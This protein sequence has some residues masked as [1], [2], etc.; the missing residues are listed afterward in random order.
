MARITNN[1]FEA[2]QKVTS[3]EEVAE[4]SVDK[5]HYCAT[6]VEHALLGYG[7]CISEQHA[8]PDENGDIAWYTVKFPTGTHK[9]NTEQ[10][11]IVEGKSH[12]HSKKMAEEN[13]DEKKLDPVGKE[14]ADIDN[15]GDTD[16]S[17]SYLH[18]RRKAIG[19]AIRKEEVEENVVSEGMPSS[20]I[21]HKQ[22][23]A[24]KTPEELHAGFKEVAQRTK[25]SVEEIARSTAWGHGYGKGEGKGSAHYWN[26]IKHLEN[27]TNEGLDEAEKKDTSAF[28][29]KSRVKAPQS[30]FEKKK[31]STGTVYTR[32]PEKE[33]E[34]KE[35]MKEGVTQTIVNHNDFVLEVTDNP[36]FKDYLEAIQSIVPATNDDI[37]K[38]IVTIATEAHKEEYVDIILESMTRKAFESKIAQLNKEG[39]KVTNINY[40]V[41]DSDPF[42]EYVAEKDGKAIQYVD[43]GVIVIS[44]NK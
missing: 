1:L 17:D 10:L 29:W 4:A 15:D 40:V 31:I 23:L 30:K 16:K 33:K 19:K 34:E 41:E 35:D 5:A 24:A 12:M 3:G 9:V 27:K 6:H 38:E 26:K 44:D 28:D 8:A 42:V 7:E 36:T 43:T 25:K 39:Y 20:V 32:K 14:D 21:K 11:R 13:I 2:I 37:H 22:R 18:N